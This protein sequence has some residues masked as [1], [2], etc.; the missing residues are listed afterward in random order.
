MLTC[1]IRNRFKEKVGEFSNSYAP[2]KALMIKTCRQRLWPQLEEA[3]LTLTSVR[4]ELG[5]YSL[6]RA[7]VVPLARP[8]TGPACEYLDCVA[9][10]TTPLHNLTNCGEKKKK[11]LMSS[12]IS[13]NNAGQSDVWPSS[14]CALDNFSAQRTIPALF[15][16]R[17]VRTWGSTG[18]G[19]TLPT[20]LSASAT[21]V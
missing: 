8:V 12:R 21:Q 4:N 13:H 16:E 11:V 2:N 3:K 20:C 10:K 1:Q 7:V 15:S 19:V 17:A 6:A 14:L 18:V 5:R 9:V